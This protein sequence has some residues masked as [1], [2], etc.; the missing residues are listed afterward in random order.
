MEVVWEAEFLG[1]PALRLDSAGTRAVLLLDGLEYRSLQSA[2]FLMVRLHRELFPG[3]AEGQP[4]SLPLYFGRTLC[5]GDF[6]RKV[7]DAPLDM[8][9]GGEFREI[10]A[11]PVTAVL[12]PFHDG[13]MGEEGSKLG[14]DLLGLESLFQAGKMKVFLS[15]EAA[16]E[17]LGQLRVF[18]GPHRTFSP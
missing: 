16:E 1:Y 11:H 15:G 2:A 3:Q 5:I 4:L 17:L 18:K 8:P 14:E 12:Q 9:V 13:F 6:F 10:P 7:A